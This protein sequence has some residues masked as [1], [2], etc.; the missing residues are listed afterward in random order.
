MSQLACIVIMDYANCALNILNFY[1]LCRPQRPRA[2][3]NDSSAVFIFFN[4]LWIGYITKL[5]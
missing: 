5:L 2:Q 1:A 3:R 4:L